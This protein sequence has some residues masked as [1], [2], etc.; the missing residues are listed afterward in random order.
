MTFAHRATGLG[1]AGLGLAGLLLQPAVAEAAPPAPAQVLSAEQPIPDHVDQWWYDAMGLAEAQRK[2][3][4]GEGAH[5]AVIDGY[6]DPTVPDL[7]GADITMAGGCEGRPADKIRGVKAS[8]GTAMVTALVGQGTGNASGGR[9]VLGVAPKAKLDFYSAKENPDTDAIDCD[10]YWVGPMIVEAAENGADVISMSIGGGSLSLM[11]KEIARAWELGAVVVAAS[12]SS[13]SVSGQVVDP[14]SVPGV[15]SVAAADTK[16]GPWKGNPRANTTFKAYISLI[17]P[18]IETPLGGFTE[19]SQWVSGA[20]RTGTSGATAITAGAF[21]LLAATYPDAT[22]YQLIQAMTHAGSL[23]GGLAW[24]I[25]TGFGPV[26]ITKALAQDPAGW[27]DEN[28]LVMLPKKAVKTYPKSVYGA[29]QDAADDEG[30]G[31]SASA[32]PAD[33]EAGTP[34]S[35]DGAATGGIPVAALAAGGVLGLAVLAG[36][37]VLARRRRSAGP[38]G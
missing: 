30:G 38:P 36:A 7:K 25:T 28:P 2:A 3:D 33:A 34:A 29:Q 5:I 11:E 32:E 26:N 17:A 14:A 6:L 10:G 9:G 1:L 19:D 20:P 27:P 24:K 23:D 4:F 35:D 13:D 22:P 12:G 18:G 8:H 16:A 15:V 21:A 37:V 31:E